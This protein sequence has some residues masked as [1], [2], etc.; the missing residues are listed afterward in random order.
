MSCNYI[1]MR[2]ANDIKS[3]FSVSYFTFLLTQHFKII[4]FS[5]LSD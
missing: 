4:N 5:T 1:T 3:G 2:G